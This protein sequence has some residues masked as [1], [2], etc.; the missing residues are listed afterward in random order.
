MATA[1]PVSSAD[2]KDS[3]RGLRLSVVIPCLNAEATLGE[4]LEALAE[5]DWPGWWE[6]IVADNGSSDG[7]RELVER[8]RR[9]LPVLRSV[10]AG[11]RP[12]QAHARNVG[13]AAA[14]GEALLF[15]DADD[16]VAPGWISALG[17][18]LADH[19]FVASRYEIERL[20][21]PAIAASRG[22][23]QADGLN[24]YTY[25]AFLPHAGGGG[26]GVR[27]DLH[28][29]VGGFN[30]S[31]AVLE[32]TDYCWRIQLVGTPLRFV[33]EAVVHIRYRPSLEGIFR[34]TLAYGEQ[35]VAIYKAY[36]DRGMPRLGWLPGLARWAKLLLTSPK[37][38]LASRRASWIH[39][40]AWRLGRLRGCLK[41]RVAAW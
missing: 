3:A 26:L 36:R 24:P 25:P 15:C 4:Q 5:Q 13:A 20:N 38:L 28:E 41:Y 10:D 9:R 14:R 1:S 30:E 8:Y 27:R 32:D 39:Q 19:P 31:L 12:G 35:N 16:M 21:S 18:A 40:L 7:S 6:V 2:Q 22:N 34:Q 11:D 17:K 23:P 29:K 33:S 37:L